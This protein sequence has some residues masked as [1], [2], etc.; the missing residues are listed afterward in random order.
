MERST[1][2]YGNHKTVEVVGLGECAD[3]EQSNIKTKHA[4]TAMVFFFGT[5]I[6][7]ELFMVDALF[8]FY[9]T[10][11]GCIV[12]LNVNVKFACK[13]AML[14]CFDSKCYYLLIL[15]PYSV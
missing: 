5:V 9:S 1:F 6:N 4:F 3:C 15:V 12:L 11:D 13:S 10:H 7:T 2:C 14:A 8:L